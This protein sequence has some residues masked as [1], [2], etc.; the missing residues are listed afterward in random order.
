[1][2]SFQSSKLY[3]KYRCSESKCDLK[4]K[5]NFQAKIWHPV[6]HPKGKIYF[7]VSRENPKFFWYLIFTHSFC[8]LHRSIENLIAL[9]LMQ[10]LQKSTM[11]LTEQVY[12]ESE[13]D[14]KVIILFQ[15]EWKNYIEFKLNEFYLSQLLIICFFSFHAIFF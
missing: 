8:S 4:E 2:P 13:R 11:N 9:K 10:S 1:M 3:L 14:F 7:H 12:L 15:V 6:K 5:K